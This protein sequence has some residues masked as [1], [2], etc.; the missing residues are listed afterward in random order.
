MNGN[1]NHPV[2][3]PV[4]EPYD[5]ST[6]T[7]L[8][9]MESRVSVVE[10]DVA[11]IRSSFATKDDLHAVQMLLLDAIKQQGYELRLIID[12]RTD[13]LAERIQGLEILLREQRAEL[14][15]IIHR[16]HTDLLDVIHAQRTDLLDVIHNQRTEIVAAFNEQRAD[17]LKYMVSQAWRL[18]AFAAVLL[19]AVYFIAR[20]IH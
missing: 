9:R 4:R 5:E 14:L 6:M 19:G 11:T 20:T 7:R 15:D 3:K 13:A 8:A 16:Q 17:T 12:T 10:V 1:D 18:Y 2:E